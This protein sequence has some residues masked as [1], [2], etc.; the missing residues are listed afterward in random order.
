MAL[1]RIYLFGGTASIFGSRDVT[2]VYEPATD[3][4]TLGEPM[5]TSRGSPAVAV[6]ND[7]IYVIGGTINMYYR[8]QANEL[9]TPI[10]YGAPDPSYDTTAP[11]ISISSPENKAY[12]TSNVTLCFAVNETT[13]QISYNLDG[14]DNVT[15]AGNT[16]LA[17]L[18]IGVH[19]VTVYAWDKF[20][21]VGASELVV[22]T[23]AEPE[24]EFSPTTLVVIASVTLLAVVGIGLLFYFKKR[25]K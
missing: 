19:N 23:I 22:F 15:V 4:W 20:G 12:Y 9:Y 24:P 3:T 25:K 13:S 18:N 8:S 2:Q 10:G 6:V 21:N 11:K 16:T 17:D 1:K 7:Q 5:P 14:R